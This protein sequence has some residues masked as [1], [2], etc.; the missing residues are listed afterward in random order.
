[1]IP[2]SKEKKSNEF[3]SSLQQTTDSTTTEKLVSVDLSLYFKH[4]SFNNFLSFFPISFQALNL[5]TEYLHGTIVV[6]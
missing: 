2:F 1:M 4:I 3:F 5:S 6:I